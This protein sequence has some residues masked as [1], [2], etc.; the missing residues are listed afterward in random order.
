[1]TSV[2]IDGTDRPFVHPFL[3][4]C[5]MFLGEI[6]CLIAFKIVYFFATRRQVRC[7]TY[8]FHSPGID[9]MIEA[10]SLEPLKKSCL[11]L[12][13]NEYIIGQTSFQSCHFLP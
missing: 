11:I 7:D 1:M 12:S 8:W 5:G 4:A 9:E 10:P 3:Q 13:V 2:G 6:L